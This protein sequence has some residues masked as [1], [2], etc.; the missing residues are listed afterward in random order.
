[1]DASPLLSRSAVGEFLASVAA[2]GFASDQCF[3]DTSGEGRKHRLG[4]GALWIKRANRPRVREPDQ[5]SEWN[6]ICGETTI[7]SWH[8]GAVPS[9]KG[10]TKVS[11]DTRSAGADRR[12]LRKGESLIYRGMERADGNRF[13]EHRRAEKANQDHEHKLAAPHSAQCYSGFGRESSL[14]LLATA[15]S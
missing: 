15:V 3:H 8:G 4:S 5:A 2:F 11:R 9:G 6:A 14:F 12:G 10:S 1:M 7:G 13:S